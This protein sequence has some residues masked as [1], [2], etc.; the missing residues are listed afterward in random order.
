MRW[1]VLAVLLAVSGCGSSPKT[2]FYTLVP[3]GSAHAP[4]SS[5]RGRPLQVGHVDLPGTLDRTAPV[6][7]GPGTQV[8]V[9][10]TDRWAAPIDELLQRALTDDLRARLGSA[11]VLAPGEPTP[12]AG[13]REVVLTVQRFIADAT[14]LVVLQADWTIAAGSPSKPGPIHHVQIQAQASNTGG[15]AVAAAMS[16]ALGTLA[17]DIVR[18]SQQD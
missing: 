5:L 11:S 2:Q 18:Q 14:G 6:T 1:L 8:D 13:A 4:P 15:G 9:S 12:K 7:Q 17:D 10:E 16:Q 3:V